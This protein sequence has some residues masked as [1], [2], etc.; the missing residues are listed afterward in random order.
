VAVVGGFGDALLGGANG[1]G[2]AGRVATGVVVVGGLDAAKRRGR[3]AFVQFVGAL[4]FV[5]AQ[6]LIGVWVGVA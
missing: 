3:A 6:R 5:S 4:G 1:F 2:D